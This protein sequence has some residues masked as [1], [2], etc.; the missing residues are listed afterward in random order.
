MPSG[1]SRWEKLGSHPRMVDDDLSP[2][3]GSTS[4]T[5]D[6]FTRTSAG[7]GNQITA[8]LRALTWH[9]WRLPHHSNSTGVV[10]FQAGK[11]RPKPL[12]IAS[13]LLVAWVLRPGALGQSSLQ[14]SG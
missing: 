11:L 13:A 12:S 7:G 2:S 10:P 3:P 8:R 14:E 9:I 4:P 1:L 5:W 6:G